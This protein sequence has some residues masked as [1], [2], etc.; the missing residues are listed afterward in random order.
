MELSPDMEAALGVEAMREPM[1]V[2]VWQE[3]ILEKL[4][5]D[6]LS[7]CTPRNTVAA[8]DLILASMTFLHWKEMSLV[9]PVQSSMRSA[10][11]IVSHL[12]STSGTYLHCFWRRC[13]PHSGIC[14]MQGQYAPVSACGAMQ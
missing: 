9:V 13:A 2:T 4:N 6:G 12:R 10:S 5:L 7:N 8:W 14:W 11:L 3:K 1:S